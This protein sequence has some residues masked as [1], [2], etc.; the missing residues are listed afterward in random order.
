M[1][2]F[3]PALP[4]PLRIDLCWFGG[5][6]PPLYLHGMHGH[7]YFEVLLIEGG[8][9]TH[10]IGH[11]H[12]RVAPGDLFLLAPGDVHD[13]AGLVRTRG[14]FLMFSADAL[15]AARSDGELFLLPRDVVLLPFVR[16]SGAAAPRLRV[17]RAR[18]A[19]FVARWRELEEELRGRRTAWQDAARALLRMI[20]VEIARLAAIPEVAPPARALVLDVF[21]FIDERYRR[22][23]GLRDVAR[24]VGRSPAYLTSMVRR[25][26]GR[27]IVAWIAERR[28]AEARRLLVT[29][30][31]TLSEVA[32]AIGYDDVSYF[33]RRFRA[34]NGLA[35]AAW[36]RE[37]MAAG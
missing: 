12:V 19:G 2:A 16:R 11:Q 26:T 21:R 24:A 23:I 10:R 6:H 31:R 35:P 3:E 14:C 34:M 29:T 33:I 28:M 18:L 25:E 30:D 13:T 9:G 27:P 8:P 36:R 7:L 5:A 4:S 37:R 1:L 17:P 32:A 20:L 15:D 22:P